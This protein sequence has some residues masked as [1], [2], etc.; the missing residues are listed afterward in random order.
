LTALAAPH[1]SVDP[2]RDQWMPEGFAAPAEAKLGEA[3]GFLPAEQR[4]T[5]TTWWLAKV[6]NAN[7]PNWD[8]ASTAMIDGRPGLLLV[9]AKAHVKELSPEGKLAVGHPANHARI[10]CAIAEANSGLSTSVPGWSLSRDACYQLANRFAWSWKLATMG[11]PVVLVY[12]GFLGAREMRDL[13]PLLADAPSWDRL[14][15]SHAR[16]H[17]PESVWERTLAVGPTSL[18]PLIR[19]IPATAI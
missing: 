18:T 8:L 13:G 15:K 6:P 2:E 4:G 14:V 5:I 16:G 12:L 7:T 1:A 17:V 3:P 9:E 19:S 10:E 11:I